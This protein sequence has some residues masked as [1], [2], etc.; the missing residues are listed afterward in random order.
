MGQVDVNGPVFASL[1]CGLGHSFCKFDEDFKKRALHVVA[2]GGWPCR[3]EKMFNY[4]PRCAGLILLVLASQLAAQESTSASPREQLTQFVADLQKN[5][6]D[7]ALRE[8]I[9]KLWL[10]LDPKPLVPREAVEHE[11]AAEYAFKHAQSPGDFKNVANE[12]EKALLLAPWVAADYYNLGLC[13]DK[14]GDPRRALA[15]YQLY[16]VA[17]PDARDTN[18]VVKQIGALKYQLSQEQQQKQTEGR[19]QQAELNAERAR[20]EARFQ[21]QERERVEN[22]AWSGIWRI[23]GKSYSNVHWTF[24]V[25]NRE[26]IL[27]AVVDRAN[28]YDAVGHRV[29]TRYR[30]NLDC[31]V[32]VS[33]N[34]PAA[35][36][37]LNQRGD[38]ILDYEQWDKSRPVQTLSRVSQ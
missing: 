13:Y 23:N 16:L 22:Q 6:S 27:T 38:T 33:V 2:P 26:L 7:D 15:A 1:L 18:E 11:G 14:T 19:Q 5:P 8:K 32:A 17:A 20:E 35:R 25:R 4:L 24:E 28:K 34:D 10:A 37:E 29:V 9:I 3:S 36:L 31:R 30:C 12:Y 21:E